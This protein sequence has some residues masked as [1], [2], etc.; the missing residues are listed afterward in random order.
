MGVLKVEYNCSVTVEVDLDMKQVTGFVVWDELLDNP[1]GVFDAD[2]TD[3]LSDT[4]AGRE[5][6]RIAA[7]CPEWPCR[8]FGA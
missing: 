5:A 8:E 6:M 4:D 2:R 1:V 3:D 7:E